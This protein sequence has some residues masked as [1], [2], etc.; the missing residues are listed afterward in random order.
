[1]TEDERCHRGPPGWKCT[2]KV[3]HEGPCAAVPDIPELQL[4]DHALEVLKA[5][6]DG[7][8]DPDERDEACADIGSALNSGRYAML[9]LERLRRR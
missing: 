7:K 1:M 9:E 8:L 5:L 2:R 3:W 4:V 6:R